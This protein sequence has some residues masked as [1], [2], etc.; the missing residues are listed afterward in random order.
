[1]IGDGGFFGVAVI[2]LGLFAIGSGAFAVVRPGPKSRGVALFVVLST[3]LLGLLGTGVG[4]YEA[5]AVTSSVGLLGKALG[6]ALVPTTLAAGLSL[7]AVVLLGVS[8]ARQRAPVA[9]P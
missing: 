4:M 8:R 2:L 5:S 6:I 1:M 9:F 7:P 3:V